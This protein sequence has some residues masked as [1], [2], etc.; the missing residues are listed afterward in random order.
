[1][2]PTEQVANIDDHERFKKMIDKRAGPAKLTI[3]REQNV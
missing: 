1:M 2:K 3:I